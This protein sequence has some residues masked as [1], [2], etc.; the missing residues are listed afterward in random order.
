MN[1][2][3]ILVASLFIHP[4]QEVEFRQFE[5]QAVRVMKKYGGRIENVIR[6]TA[7][8]PSGSSPHEIHIVSFPSM[9]QFEAYRGDAELAKLAPLR[10]SAIARTEIVIGE[11]GEPYL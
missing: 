3:I 11:E 6:P 2:R 8:V 4:G 9:E 7:S 5:T 10:Q 1:A